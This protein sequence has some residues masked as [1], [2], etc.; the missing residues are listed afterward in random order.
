MFGAVAHVLAPKKWLVGMHS[1]LI[2]GGMPAAAAAK[3]LAVL[4]GT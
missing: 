3:I 4:A 2:F 1:F